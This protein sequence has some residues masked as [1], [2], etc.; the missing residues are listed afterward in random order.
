MK[1]SKKVSISITTSDG[2]TFPCRLT[3]GAMR[4]YKQ[5]TGADADNISGAADLSVFI[6]CCCVSACSADG[7]E[8]GYSIEDFCD[9]VDVSAIETFSEAIAPDGKKK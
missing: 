7:I 8:F 2:K 6:W 1:V 4:R 9:R 3:L 5:I